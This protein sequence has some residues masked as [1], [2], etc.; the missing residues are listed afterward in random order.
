MEDTATIEEELNLI[1]NYIYIL[2]VR[3]SGDI[4][5]TKQVDESLLQQK[6]PRMVLQPLVENAVK[7]GI[8]E[9]DYP[10]EIRLRIQGDESHVIISVEDNGTGMT[11][12]Q[13]ERILME[14]GKAGRSLSDSNG[15]GLQNVKNRLVL[16]Y[17]EKDI[18][19]IESKGKNQGTTVKIQIPKE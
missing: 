1:D 8:L 13:I 9:V 18:L 7:Y 3:Y 5:Y 17:N 16:Y 14:E 6:I 4:H 11:K 10:G 2:N 19:Q 12:N 15:V